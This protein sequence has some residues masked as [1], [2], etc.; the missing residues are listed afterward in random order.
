MRLLRDIREGTKLLLLLELVRHRHTRLRGLADKLGVT[1]AAVSEYVKAMEVEGL[2]SH[3]RGEY[4]ATKEGLEYLQS[5]VL[6]LRDFVEESLSQVAII[7]EAI[8]LARDEIEE[9]QDVGLFMEA[10]T[11]VARNRASPST[12]TAAFEASPGDAVLVRNLRGI[13]AL[14]PGKIGILRLPTPRRSGRSI[15]EACRRAVRRAKPDV[16]AALD[17]HA[18]ALCARLKLRPI[19]FASVPASIEAA[20]R[21][22]N[23]LLFC[24]E[25][26]VGEV[27]AAIEA[28]NDRSEDKIPY[29]TLAIA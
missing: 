28:A 6:A 17:V 2:V 1:V 23:V 13:V 4:R 7:D 10:G 19:E 21:G 26:R 3:G 24:P 12:G 22:L 27:V 18:K 8:A 15:V 5:H 29:E 20:Q 11:L 16:V 9:G 25:E 14:A